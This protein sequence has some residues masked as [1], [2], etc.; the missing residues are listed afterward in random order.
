M[1]PC[2]DGIGTVGKEPETDADLA[3]LARERVVKGG[4][5]ADIAFS[6]NSG[7]AELHVSLLTP[8]PNCVRNSRL[9]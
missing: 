2:T 6:V 1:E 7:G 8:L 5:S 3:R 9:P 4:G